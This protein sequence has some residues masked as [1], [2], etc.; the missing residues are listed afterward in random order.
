MRYCTRYHP[1]NNGIIEKNSVFMDYTHILQE[2][3]AER[4]QIDAAIL[5]LQ[6]IGL[7]SSAPKRRG[8]P[9]KNSLAGESRLAVAQKRRKRTPEQR[10]AQAERMRQYWA[11]RKAKS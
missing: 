1:D 5:A 10:E 3:K 8:R 7:A 9:P 4:D 11:T 6:G 2:L